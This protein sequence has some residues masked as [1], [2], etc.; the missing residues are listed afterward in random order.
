MF[1]IPAGKLLAEVNGNSMTYTNIESANTD[2]VRDTLMGY[3]REIEEALSDLIPRG[4]TVKFKVEELLR[5][6]RKTRYEGHN[7]AL[8]GQPFKTVNEIRAEEGLPP[9]AG[10]DV[11][12]TK[13]SVTKTP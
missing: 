6:D 4:Q 11:L 8:A 9:I 5:A 13:E 3:L 1:G 7:L 2:Y 12:P 10:G